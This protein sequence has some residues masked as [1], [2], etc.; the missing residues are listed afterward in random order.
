[1]WLSYL[2]AHTPIHASTVYILVCWRLLIGSGRALFTAALR[3][4]AFISLDFIYCM[5]LRRHIFYDKAQPRLQRITYVTPLVR[6]HMDATISRMISAAWCNWRM[7]AAALSGVPA[8]TQTRILRIEMLAF[9]FF[10]PFLFRFSSTSSKP[11]REGKEKKE[12]SLTCS[13]PA[14]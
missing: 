9:F 3:G 14:T 11:V 13:L 4:S 1:M 8:V 2:G 7:K 10:S 5:L 6:H 12:G